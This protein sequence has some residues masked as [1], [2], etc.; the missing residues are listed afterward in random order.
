M[1]FYDQHIQQT[2]A[3]DYRFDAI[4]FDLSYWQEQADT[5]ILDGGR[6]G[7]FLI[8]LQEQPFVLH[9]YLRGGL[10]ARVLYD[11]YIWTGLSQTRPYQEMQ[12]VN[13]ALDSGLPVPQLVA[14]QVKKSGFFYRAVSISRYIHNRGSLA[15]LIAEE[16][17]SL[18]Q[19]FQLGVAIKK[20]HACYIDH[21]DLNAN[22]ILLRDV[23]DFYL[24]DFDKATLKVSGDD[25]KLS[26]LNRLKRSLM[27]I[28]SLL[29]QQGK[30]F[31]FSDIDWSSFNK[32]YQA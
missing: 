13:H 8:Y 5:K 12:V 19:W 10:L 6:G 16:P 14:F 22:N 21:A 27:K 26:N 3:I 9:Q 11:Q 23:T 31:Y 28:Q 1:N 29:Q 17:L 25:W 2:D 7:S 32:G 15:A 30:T 4:E 24:I 20:M 18:E